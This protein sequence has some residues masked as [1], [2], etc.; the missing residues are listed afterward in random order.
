M[1]FKDMNRAVNWRLKV[2]EQKRTDNAV[3]MNCC[4]SGKKKDDGT[5]EKSLSI[6]VVVSEKTEWP[7]VGFS[8][9]MILATGGFQH[10]YWEKDSKSGFDFTI[11]AD[12]VEEY[13]YTKPANET[14]N[15]ES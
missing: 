11:F 9:K 4:L 5:Y 12:K 8:G 6:R 14:A 2:F 7:R 13:E 15:W 3:I 10:R 1:D